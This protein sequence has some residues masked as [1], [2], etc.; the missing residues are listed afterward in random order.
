MVQKRHAVTQ[1]DNKNKLALIIQNGNFLCLSCSRASLASQ[2]DVFVSRDS[3]P[4][5]GLSTTL[6][7]WGFLLLNSPPPPVLF[8]RNAVMVFNY[9]K[10]VTL[11]NHNKRRCQYHRNHLTIRS[12]KKTIVCIWIFD[13]PR[14]R[15]KRRPLLSGDFSS[16]LQ[17]R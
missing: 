17:R 8:R 6:V 1:K 9:I 11:A 4:A 2:H 5:K 16:L 10:W 12:P 3:S 13:S 7:I 15:T 14:D